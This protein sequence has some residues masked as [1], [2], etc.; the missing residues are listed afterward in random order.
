MYE[1]R[2]DHRPGKHHAIANI[3]T[4]SRKPSKQWEK[5]FLS[6]VSQIKHVIWRNVF[7]MAKIP[8]SD[9]SQNTSR[10]YNSEK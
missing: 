3:N 10:N 6:M 9:Q 2:I 7:E 8:N 4:H 5:N 1:M